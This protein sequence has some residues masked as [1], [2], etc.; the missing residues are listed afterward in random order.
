MSAN[1]TQESGFPDREKAVV[2]LPHAGAHGGKAQKSPL[3]FG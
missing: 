1:V 2:V 3:H